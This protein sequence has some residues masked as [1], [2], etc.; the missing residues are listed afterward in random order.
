VFMLPG[1]IR[2]DAG[3]FTVAVEYAADNTGEFYAGSVAHDGDGCHVGTNLVRT[4]AGGWQD[5]RELGFTGDW[6]IDAW[7][8]T[9]NGVVAFGNEDVFDYGEIPLGETHCLPAFISNI[10]T[11]TLTVAGFGGNLAPFFVDTMLTNHVLGPGES[12]TFEICVTSIGGTT[13]LNHAIRVHSNANN[14]P[15]LYSLLYTPPVQP[16]GVPGISSREL[17][18]TGIVP[19]PFNPETAIHFVL[20]VPDAV[21]AEVWSI[22]G[23]RVRTLES[24]AQY[25]GGSNI[26]RWD[27]RDDGGTPAASGVYFL[28]VRA[29]GS[30]RTARMVLLK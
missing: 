2:L 14:S 13:K 15:T 10:G 8:T 12:T 22:T 1:L 3:T 27:G 19:N 26:I 18:I 23:A 7:Y 5:A 4:L 11:D 28:R 25:P 17:R 29:G 6:A 16:T 24:G 9:L 20:P 21:Y 30:Q